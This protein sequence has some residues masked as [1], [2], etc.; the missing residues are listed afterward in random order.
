MQAWRRLSETELQEELRLVDLEPAIGFWNPKSRRCV[1]QLRTPVKLPDHVTAPLMTYSQLFD[2]HIDQVINMRTAGPHK[3][4]M[5]CVPPVQ[6][7]VADQ[8]TI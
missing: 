8:L 5:H 2:G 6:A 4:Y 3:A 1:P 7:G